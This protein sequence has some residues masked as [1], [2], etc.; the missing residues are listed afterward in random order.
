MNR[1]GWENVF[2]Q[3]NSASGTMRLLNEQVLRRICAK[4]CMFF[5]RALKMKK[6]ICLLWQLIFFVIDHGAFSCTWKHWSSSPTN[7]TTLYDLWS[8]SDYWRYT[9][10]PWLNSFEFKFLLRDMRS[11]SLINFRF[12]SLRIVKI[13]ILVNQNL[14]VNNT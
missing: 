3:R 11:W 4:K 2:T 10:E 7:E 13:Y 8:L 6:I 5:W 9:G 14:I 1:Y 12:T